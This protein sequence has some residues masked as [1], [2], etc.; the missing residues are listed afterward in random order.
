MLELIDNQAVNK[1]PYCFISLKPMFCE[2][3]DF[4]NGIKSTLSNTYLKDIVL[5]NEILYHPDFYDG[6]MCDEFLLSVFKELQFP[7]MEFA[8]KYVIRFVLNKA[9]LLQLNIT[10]KT[11]TN[12]LRQNLPNN[13]MYHMLASEEHDEMLVIRIRM[14]NLTSNEDAFEKNMAYTFESHL[15]NTIHIC[16]IFG[17]S[18]ASTQKIAYHEIDNTSNEVIS[19]EKLQ[20]Q[21]GGCNMKDLWDVNFVDWKNTWTNNVTEI[22]NHLG[23]EAGIYL[24]YQE[25]THIL[26]FDGGFIHSKHIQLLT[27]YM[28][29]TGC[30]LPLTRHGFN[31]QL[32]TGPISRLLFEECNS[33]LFDSSVF[34]EKNINNGIG[35]NIMF[36]QHFQGG[37]GSVNFLVDESKLKPVKKYEVVR[38]YFS[39]YVNTAKQTIKR[40]EIKIEKKENHYS[41]IYNPTSPKYTTTSPIYNPTS[42]IYNRTSPVYKTTSPS[43]H[44]TS[45]IYNPTSPVYTIASPKSAKYNTILPNYI[46]N[47]TETIINDH[48]QNKQ[49]Q[50]KTSLL[51]KFKAKRLIELSESDLIFKKIK[52]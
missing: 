20:I 3:E 34:A 26:S 17:L 31:K 41:P 46:L 48:I 6:S 14:L 18:Y 38:T 1:T 42:P 50:N 27:S 40:K 28:S 13:K 7:S 49:N 32:G 5:K 51:S 9:K 23:L 10:I 47:Q 30:I 35:D 4:V 37:T 2:R 24:L 33:I 43:Y 21:I 44:P 19:K 15:L 52:Q 39:E 25:L 8:S 11:V 22:V 45:P 36:G 29:H 16:G 12:L